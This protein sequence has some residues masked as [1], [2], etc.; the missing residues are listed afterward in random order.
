[1]KKLENPIH[2]MIVGQNQGGGALA[3]RTKFR[4]DLIGP[5][6]LFGPDG[7]RIEISSR[8]GIALIGL[9]AV[10]PGGRRTREYLRDMLW[11]T[12]GE[13][14]AQDSLRRELSNLRKCLANGGAELLLISEMQRVGLDIEQL[15]IDLFSLGV[16]NANHHWRA[17]GEFLEGLD[18]P[19]GERFEDWLREERSRVEDLLLAE[20]DIIASPPPSPQ[21]IYG[22]DVPVALDA[23]TGAGPSL[24]P[25]P[26]IAVLPFASPGLS[27]DAWLGEA[28][29]DSVE[30]LVSQFPQ[31][32]VASGNSSRLLAGKGLTSKQVAEQLGV[33]YLIE[34]RVL[35]IAGRLRVTVALVDGRSGEQMWADAVDG[36]SD[37]LWQ[38]QDE[39]GAHIA[40]RIWTMVDLSERD[41]G[42]RQLSRPQSSYELYW[43]A[44]ALFRSWHPDAM[45]EAAQ[46]ADRLAADNPACVWSASLAAYCHSVNFI[47]GYAPDR[48]A[49]L[50]RASHYC[51]VAIRHGADNVE[52]LGYCA[53]TIINIGGNLDNAD[54]LVTRALHILP[55]FQPTLFWGGWVDVFRGDP[56]RARERFELAL[57]IN[58]A[59]GA[60]AQTL[61][62]LGM[63]ALLE[64]RI[65]EARRFF[66]EAELEEPAFPITRIGKLAAGGFAGR[67]P[68]A[69]VVIDPASQKQGLALLALF[70][71]DEDRALFAETLGVGGYPGAAPRGKAA[72][73]A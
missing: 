43:R 20:R 1:M 71:R 6:G 53:G 23:L 28:I 11:E 7:E 58:P 56:A 32:F 12:R 31:L 41:R 60:R 46:L 65:D 26:S 13:K 3:N 9:L 39:I 44:N 50:Q 34:G 8:K 68:G 69:V 10:S 54:R 5:F 18:L 57:R 45:F 70:R 64:R 2:A 37:D 25:K 72:H 55:A 40:P 73:I 21:E 49:A 27:T 15:E 30:K 67:E 14:Q 24:P 35:Q 16:G 48:Q 4:L 38:L 59:S 66:T 62:G 33:T 17:S 47:M 22:G 29:A 36:R 42:L 52:A 61:C 19:A 51:Q 63:A